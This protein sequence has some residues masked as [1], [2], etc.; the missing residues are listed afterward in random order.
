V[1]E[2]RFDIRMMYFREKNNSRIFPLN[3]TQILHNLITSIGTNNYKQNIYGMSPYSSPQSRP[4][5]DCKSNETD[6]LGRPRLG[7]TATCIG[8]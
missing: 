4:Q 1:H 6:F 8:P 2:T 5:R 3:Y 7:G